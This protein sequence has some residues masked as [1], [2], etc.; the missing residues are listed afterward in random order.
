MT[1]FANFV[2]PDMKLMNTWR[3]NAS[4]PREYGVSNWLSIPNGTPH[5]FSPLEDWWNGNIVGCGAPRVFALG[6]LSSMCYGMF[7]ESEIGAPF[8][9]TFLTVLDI[10]YLVMEDIRQVQFAFAWEMQLSPYFV[11]FPFGPYVNNFISF[12]LL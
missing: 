1:K 8:S 11:S 4:S 12:S 10:A 3:V 9:V 5:I 6:K 7:R 2:Y